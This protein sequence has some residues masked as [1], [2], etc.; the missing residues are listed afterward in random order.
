[1]H[2]KTH[3]SP[4]TFRSRACAILYPAANVAIRTFIKVDYQDPNTCN[5]TVVSFKCVKPEDSAM[6]K[7]VSWSKA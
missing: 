3:I 6:I 1:M 7:A 4:E 2:F 5:F